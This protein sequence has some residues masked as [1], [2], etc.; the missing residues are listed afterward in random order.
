MRVTLC[1]CQNVIMREIA[2]PEMAPRDVAQTYRLAMESRESLDWAVVNSAIIA[3]WDVTT[4]VKIKKMAH[5][6]KCFGAK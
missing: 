1:D 6:G 5:S 2:M 3:R 4:L